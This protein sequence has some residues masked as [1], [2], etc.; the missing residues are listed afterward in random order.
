MGSGCGSPG[1]FALPLR[2]GRLRRNDGIIRL[3]PGTAGSSA[4]LFT[5]HVTTPS[6]I[7]LCALRVLLRKT[8]PHPRTKNQELRTKNLFTLHVSRITSSPVSSFKFPVSR[9]HVSR[10]TSSRFPSFEFPV[11]SFQFPVSRLHVSRITSSRLTS[12]PP[13]FVFLPLFTSFQMAFCV[14]LVGACAQPSSIALR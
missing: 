11:S 6:P 9:L 7:S 3:P 5:H 4:F 8:S 1:R 2:N 13:H 14:S 10:I 12:S